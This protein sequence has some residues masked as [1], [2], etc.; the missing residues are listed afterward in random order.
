M[1]LLGQVV[2]RCGHA[3]EEEGFGLVLAAM[4]IWGG[5]QFLGLGH[6]HGG[7]QAGEDGA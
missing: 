2:H 7:V 3:I 1:G 6:G 4:A 5:H